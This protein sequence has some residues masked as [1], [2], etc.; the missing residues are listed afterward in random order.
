MHDKGKGKKGGKDEKVYKGLSGSW[1]SGKGK[2]KHF[3]NHEPK[4]KGKKQNDEVQDNSFLTKD[5]K[6]RMVAQEN[7]NE[8]PG[9]QQQ[10]Q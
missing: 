8:T 9:H 2:G 1:Q 3:W 5:C 6:V 4:G 7:R 10:Q